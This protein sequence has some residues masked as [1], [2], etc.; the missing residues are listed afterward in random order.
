MRSFRY[1][2]TTI[3][4]CGARARE[5]PEAAPRR[6]SATCRAGR[7][8]IRHRRVHRCPPRRGD[9]SPCPPE[10]SPRRPA[11]G[12]SRRWPRPG[13]SL[14]SF[15]SFFGA[16][17]EEVDPG[18]DPA[19]ASS[20]EVPSPSSSDPS[21]PRLLRRGRRVAAGVLVARV[22]VL[23]ARRRNGGGAR[24]GRRL[25]VR[26]RGQIRRRLGLFLRRRDDGFEAFGRGGGDVGEGTSSAAAPA[27]TTTRRSSSGSGPR[28]V[29]WIPSSR[30]R[31]PR[32]VVAADDVRPVAEGASSSGVLPPAAVSS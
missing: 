1:S 21:A 7:S 31:V 6:T 23:G 18:R 26:L 14:L 11:L 2:A 22:G 30:P 27:T 29:P 24:G 13:A 8:S 17:E 20:P 12:G 25:R 32:D 15:L 5:I 28:G 10:T 19:A 3:A 4:S 16:L 9:E